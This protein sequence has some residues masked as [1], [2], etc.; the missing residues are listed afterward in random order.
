V[1]GTPFVIAYRIEGNAVVVLR[2]MH[3]AQRWPGTL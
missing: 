2:L 3:G 1:N